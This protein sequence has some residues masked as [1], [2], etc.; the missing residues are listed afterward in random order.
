MWKRHKDNGKGG[1]DFEKV[2]EKELW[3]V[4]GFHVDDG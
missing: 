2:F 3:K 4:F 1:E